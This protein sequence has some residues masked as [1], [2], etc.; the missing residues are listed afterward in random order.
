MNETEALLEQLRG[1]KPPPVSQMPAPGWWVLGL[2]LLL[3]AF[4]IWQAVRR[5]RQRAWVRE[6][7]LELEGI[8]Q[9]CESR[10]VVD[11]LTAASR[12]ARRILLAVKPRSDIASMQGD[13]WLEELDTLCGRDL[14]SRGYGRMLESGP[15]QRQPD[16]KVSDLHGLF[17]VM[18]ELIESAAKHKLLDGAR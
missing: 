15:Y 10:P 9:Q 5:Y 11:S 4:L 1:I 6:A 13:R 18:G 8:R 17:D 16:I 7:Q 12:L 2:F 14:F 3:S